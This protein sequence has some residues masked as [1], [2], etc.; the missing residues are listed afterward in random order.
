MTA[1]NNDVYTNIHQFFSQLDQQ[2]SLSHASSH[3]N[4][5][6]LV[7]DPLYQRIHPV[8]QRQLFGL[9]TALLQSEYGVKISDVIVFGSCLTLY[10]NSYSD[11]DLIVLGDFDD[12]NPSI[13]FYEYGEVD[14]FGYNKD[15]FMKEMEG[16]SFY[17]K[18]WEEGYKIYEQLPT[19][20]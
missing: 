19:S 11:I 9:I 8:K 20:R 1:P 5:S 12:F 13:P 15:L 18:I 16:N 6:V 10:C 17:K 2:L 3:N 4:F 7:G 14:L